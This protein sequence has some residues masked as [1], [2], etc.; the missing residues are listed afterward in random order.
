MS[1][2]S[3]ALKKVEGN[4]AETPPVGDRE[5]MAPRPA[6]PLFSVWSVVLSTVMVLIAAGLLLFAWFANGP[7]TKPDAAAVPPS[8]VPASAQT[9]TPETA[10]AAVAAAP[11]SEPEDAAAPP[12]PTAPPVAEAP[13]VAPPGADDAE[14]PKTPPVHPSPR[15][16]PRDKR[17]EMELT[18]VVFTPRMRMAHINGK[19]LAE[20][21]EVAGYRVEAIAR[22]SVRLSKDGKLYTLQLRR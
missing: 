5:T 8:P 6:P 17:D 1:I 4:A 9:E 13:A 22:E 16:A 3:D 21:A 7:R 10:P 14:A 11:A 2:I 12:V 18:G 15:T 19:I 20:G